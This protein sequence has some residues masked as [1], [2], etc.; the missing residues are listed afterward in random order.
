[1]PMG[2]QDRSTAVQTVLSNPHE[3]S[4]YKSQKMILSVKAAC[5]MTA[6]FKSA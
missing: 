2:R 1:M 6:N 5:K 4:Q 3:K